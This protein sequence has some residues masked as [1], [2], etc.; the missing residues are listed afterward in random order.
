LV[1]KHQLVTNQGAGAAWCVCFVRAKKVMGRGGAETR[2]AD[3]V[4]KPT[5]VLRRKRERGALRES[6]GEGRPR[7]SGRARILNF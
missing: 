3:V 5:I 2:L 1:L 6:G 7:I 4:C